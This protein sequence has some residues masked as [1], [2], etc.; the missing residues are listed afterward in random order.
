MPVRDSKYIEYD[1][2]GLVNVHIDRAR[3]RGLVNEI[4]DIIVTINGMEYGPFDNRDAAMMWAGMFLDQAEEMKEVRKYASGDSPFPNEKELLSLAD[5]KIKLEAE[6]I[7]INTKL[8]LEQRTTTEL[9]WMIDR[10]LENIHPK[11]GPQ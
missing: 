2:T 11:G 7:R 6:L 9:R 1:G 10:L 3:L 5:D 4:S 8:D